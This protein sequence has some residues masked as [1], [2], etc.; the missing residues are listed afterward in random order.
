[1][2]KRVLVLNVNSVLREEVWLLIKW[3][4]K[5]S[6]DAVVNLLLFELGELKVFCIKAIVSLSDE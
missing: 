5:I 1:M 2:G 4:V 3:I 6:P